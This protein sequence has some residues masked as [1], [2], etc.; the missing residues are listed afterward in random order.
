[1]FTIG[2]V[3]FFQVAIPWIFNRPAFPMFRRS[4]KLANKLG[5]VQEEVEASKLQR[6]I[7]Q[8]EKK[9]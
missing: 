8:L 3:L 7:T 2:F 5:E 6:K 1:M 4:T 9:I